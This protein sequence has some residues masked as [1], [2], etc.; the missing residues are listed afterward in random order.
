[1]APCLGAGFNLGGSGELAV[2][3]RPALVFEPRHASL[4]LGAMEDTLAELS[5]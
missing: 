4:F 1:M 3:F 2:R 5:M